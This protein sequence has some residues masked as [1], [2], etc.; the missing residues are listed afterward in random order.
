MEMCNI[1]PCISVQIKSNW[2]IFEY[3]MTSHHIAIHYFSKVAS[4]EVRQ[5]LHYKQ[6]AVCMAVSSLAMA[7]KTNTFVSKINSQIQALHQQDEI[8]TILQRYIN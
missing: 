8:K 6:Q 5:A 3:L 2:D 4:K 1:V 7:E